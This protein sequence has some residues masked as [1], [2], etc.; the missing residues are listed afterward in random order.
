MLICP[1]EKKDEYSMFLK[2]I[3]RGNKEM[4]KCKIVSEVVKGNFPIFLRYGRKGESRKRR[5]G[6][7]ESSIPTRIPSELARCVYYHNN[8][9]KEYCETKANNSIIIIRF[10]TFASNGQTDMMT[11]ECKNMNVYDDLFHKSELSEL[12]WVC[13]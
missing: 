11:F 7:I 9:E 13:R 2:L 1:V 6:F 3:D 8:P 4:W 5:G 12:Q 10:C